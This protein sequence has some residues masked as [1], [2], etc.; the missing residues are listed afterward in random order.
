[1][2]KIGV[3]Y[4]LWISSNIA[5]GTFRSNTFQILITCTLHIDNKY[6]IELGISDNVFNFPSVDNILTLLTTF[7][8]S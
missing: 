3:I 4:F 1:M 8:Q 6:E 5:L 7:R 2:R